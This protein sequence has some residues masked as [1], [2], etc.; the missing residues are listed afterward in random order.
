[1]SRWVCPA[2]GH[3]YNRRVIQ[4]A[5]GPED[6]VC[7]LHGVPLFRNC[8]RCAAAWPLVVESPYS[9]TPSRG[10][11][12]CGKCALPAQWLS[13]DA[14]MDWLTHQVQA[15]ESVSD[16]TRVELRVTLERIKAMDANDTRAVAGWKQVKKLAPKVW[17]ATKPVRDVVI[18]EAVKKAIEVLGS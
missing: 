1:M 11:A 3:V 14:L 8:R 13:R 18:G 6:A 4:G 15:D 17:D 7:A 10:A 9:T 12:F 16:A 2:N 5:V